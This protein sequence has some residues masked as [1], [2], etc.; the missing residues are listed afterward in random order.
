MFVF[1]FLSYY[2]YP[3][4]Y[5]CY[6]SSFLMFLLSFSSLILFSFLS[7]AF[8]FFL[9]YHETSTARVDALQQCWM[10]KAEICSS[11]TAQKG[12]DSCGSTRARSWDSR[13]PGDLQISR[14]G[15][16]AR[17]SSGPRERAESPLVHPH[18]CPQPGK[19][20]FPARRSTKICALSFLSGTRR[21]DESSEIVSF[22]RGSCP[23]FF[24]SSILQTTCARPRALDSS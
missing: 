3:F 9:L 24:V 20:P 5:L 2:F 16:P 13:N 18:R 8:F 4:F 7:I 23:L 19:H 12:K 17:P 15:R 10:E 6:V 1:L 14:S 22:F 11:F 21:R